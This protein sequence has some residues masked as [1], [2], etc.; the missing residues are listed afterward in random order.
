[1]RIALFTDTYVP[2][3]NGVA[4]SCKSLHDILVAHGHQVLV[5]TSNPFGDDFMMDNDVYRLPGAELKKVYGYRMANIFNRNAINVL[6]KFEPDLIHIQTEYSVGI[7]GLMAVQLLK[8][9][10]VYTYHTMIEDYTYYLTHGHFDRIA[11]FFI[12]RYFKMYAQLADGFITPSSKTKDYMRNIGYDKYCN[13][14]PTGI[15][16]SRFNPG[17]ISPNIKPELRHKFNIDDD[18][19]T[20]LSLG[21]IAAEKSIDFSMKCYAKFIENHPEIKTKMVIVGKGPA[22]DELKQLAKDLNIA[23][24]VIFA[25]PCDPKEVQNYYTLGDAFVSASLSET[26]GLTYMEAMASRLYVMA[27]YDH[28][29]LDVVKDGVT[30]YFFENEE[31]FSNKL[32]LAYQSFKNYDTKMLDDAIKGIEQYSIETF[33]NSIMKTY[34]HV[35]KINW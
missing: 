30:G 11:K 10:M 20:V 27:R 4:M 3:I 33:Y 16:F 34:K 24:K 18:T 14:V 6:R 29:L 1:M 22:E 31:E 2:E 23:D 21:R 12:R 17:N 28:N 26:Q 9:P 7:I 8:I 19:F 13:V 32:Y 5:V 25:G 35:L 15:D